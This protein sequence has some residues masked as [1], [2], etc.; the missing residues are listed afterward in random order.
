M[1]RKVLATTLAL[2]TLAACGGGGDPTG[3]EA[4]STIEVSTPPT[5]IASLGGSVTLTATGKSSKGKNVGGVTFT[6]SSANPSVATVNNGVVT[7]VGNGTTSISAAAGSATG[8]TQVTVQ[9]V[10]TQVIVTFAS[11]TI[12]AYGDT[13]RAT[14]TARD[15][16]GSAIG[17][18]TATWTSSNPAVATVDGSGLMTAVSEGSTTIRAVSSSLQGEKT[19]QVR[20]RAARLVVTRQ[21]VG[22]RAGLA[23]ETQP[24]VEVQDS[25]GNRVSTDNSTVVTASVVGGG[26]VVAGGVASSSAGV[27]TFTNLAIGGTAGAKTL[28]FSGTSVSSATTSTFTMTFGLPSAVV[29]VGGNNQIGLAGVALPQPLQAGVRDAFGNAVSGVPVSFSIQQGGGSLSAD[30][31]TSNA[32]GNAST[33]YTLSRYAG[34]SSVRVGT[35]AAPQAQAIFEATATPNGVIRGT[36]TTAA[37]GIPAVA[38]PVAARAAAVAERSSHRV[39]PG[40]TS[41]LLPLPV[42]RSGKRVSNAPL[43]EVAVPSTIPSSAAAASQQFIPGELLVTYRPER[44]GAPPVGAASFQQASVTAAVSASIRQAVIPSVDAGLVSLTSVSPTLLTARVKVAPGATEAEVMAQ[45]RADPR[46][47][48][49]ERN[50]LMHTMVVPPTAMDALLASTGWRSAMPVPLSTLANSMQDVGT[51]SVYPFG[52]F[53]PNNALYMRQAWHYNVVSLPQAWVMTQGSTDILVAVVDDGIRFDHPA[54]ASVL[55]NDGY[56][57]VSVSTPFPL[58]A[59]GT[60]DVRGDGDGPDPNPTQPAAHD[61]NGSCAGPLKTSGNHGLHVA[62]TIGAL[63]TSSSGLT[64]VSW[65]ARIRP[66]RVLGTHGSGSFYDI[67]QGVLYAAGLPADNGAGGTVTAPGGR[68][69][70]INMSLGGSGF[71][72]VLGTAVAQAYANGSLIIAAAGNENSSTPNYPASF[73]DV[74]SVSAVAPTLNRASYSSFGTSVDLAAPGGQT[75]T[76]PSHGVLSTTWNYVT[77]QSNIDSWQ[78]TSMATPHVAGIAALILAREP[79][80]TA[81]QLSARLINFSID[82]GSPGPDQLFGSGLVNARNSMTASFNPPRQLFVRV[83]NAANGATVRTVAAA[84]NGSYEAGGLPDGQYWVFAGYDEDGD[85]LTGLPWRSWGAL[86]AA[87]GPATVL[88]DGAGNYSATFTIS[89]GFEVEPNNTAQTADELVVDGF[90]NGDLSTTSDLDFYRLRVPAQG[91][92]ALVVTGQ[93][94]ACG[95]ALEADP[96][97]T[98]FS[99]VGAQLAEN[100]D[101]DFGAN[102]LCSR[103]NVTLSPGDYLIRVGGFTAG[104][105]TLIS[106][107]L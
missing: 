83:V 27:V 11:D 9:Q 22:V 14:A 57:F 93:V 50:G 55:T 101:I 75:S 42:P 87:S 80:L 62:G 10:P 76:G 84:P 73:P 6:W 41:A 53:F 99:S 68:A 43:S 66:V 45:L 46:V 56:D 12:T 107:R 36:I 17:G 32:S 16:G 69:R 24:Q 4:V 28:Q 38:M 100:D 64:G 94:G 81:A 2:A 82:I 58:C 51:M 30:V 44:I 91:N 104:R 79:Q 97:I 1:L 85:G 65:N 29:V 5:A 34:A 70:I 60:I 37:S 90:I 63:R 35:S 13:V 20:Q 102:N 59:G 33:T 21:P 106:R 98:L 103:L 47:Q 39:L 89:T 7:A 15:A 74:V 77:N 3:P 31:V 72:T 105:Y 61:R 19:V 23:I 26:T 48:A 54:M 49:V 92:Y 25:R 71:S 96:V 95:F 67:A 52:G 88:V 18:V 86:G 8:S 40:L 78:G